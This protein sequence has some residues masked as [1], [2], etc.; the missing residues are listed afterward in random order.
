MCKRIISLLLAA[1]MLLSIPMPVRATEETQP[2]EVV[3]LRYLSISTPEEL[4]A[5]AENCRLDSYSQNLVVM[6]EQDI[7]LTGV[8]FTPIP[9]FSGYFQG[10]GHTI[11]GVNLTGEG[12]AVGFFRY[13]TETAVVE[14]VHVQGEIHP[15]GSRSTVGGISGENRGTIRGSS[16]TG[17][18][19]GGEYVGL[20]VGRNM[21]SGIIESC[22]AAGELHGDHF[23]GGIAG[24]NSGVIRNCE[25]HA[26]INTTPQQNTVD[27]SDITMDTLT[28]SESVNTVTDIGGVAGLSTGVIR[29]CVN[30]G[31]V[32]YQHMGYNIGGIAGTQSGYITDCR[33]YGSVQ[34]RKEVGGIVGQMEPVAVIEYS[35]DTLQIL[36]EQLNDMSGLVSQA[37]GNAYAN[38]SHV[39]AQMGQL[40]N[41]AQAAKDAADYLVPDLKDPTIPD[42]DGILAAQN[43]LSSNLGAMPETMNSIASATQN[44]VSGLGRDLQAVSGQISVM[45]QTVSNASE[46][47]GLTIRDCSDLDTP[48]NL[49]GKVEGCVN[50]GDLLADLNVGGIAGAMA[51]ENDLDIL[52]DWES[53]GEESLNLE[54]NLRAVLLNSENHGTVTGKKQ[55]VGGIVGWQSMGLTRLCS[56]AGNVDGEGASYVGGIS[57]LSTGFIRNCYA[58]SAIAGNTC[59]GGVAGSAGIVTDCLTMVK[60]EGGRESLGA[61]LGTQGQALT[62][63]ENPIAGNIYLSV[64]ADHGAIDGISYAGLAQPM[65]LDEFL[66]ME[67]LPELFRTVTIRF[68]FPD[69]TMTEFPLTTGQSM[70]MDVVPTVPAQAGATGVWEGLQ[71]ADLTDVLFDRTYDVKYTAYTTTIASAETRE[72]GRPIL[73]VEGAF[74]NE[75]V[76]SVEKST[77]SYVPEEGAQL[78]ES[79]VITLTEPGETARFLMPEGAKADKLTLM[80]CGAEGIWRQAEIRQDGSYLVFALESGDRDLALIRKA[81][82]EL[83]L[84]QVAVASSMATAVVVLLLTSLTKKKAKREK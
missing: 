82:L 45:S 33:N 10:G 12:S 61:I 70:S 2:K 5:L 56:S 64:G 63:V 66:A 1:L 9:I 36:Q 7:D 20:I 19:S 22:V 76:V 53:Y 30:Y 65:A 72:N 58:K 4:L 75:A 57:G 6:L 37:A 44:T 32:G 38:A 11:S 54:S 21:V 77:I 40:Q 34:G 62:E 52:Q 71:A 29:G 47:L 41:Q 28:N 79:W 18:L 23:V 68:R 59:V 17:S 78:L 51:M 27:I 46:N 50:Y 42:V 80:V 55:N 67:N 74:T 31:A 60:F 26:A 49:T 25:N 39:S 73:L 16:F 69:G 8:A 35:Q 3:E 83:T 84:V 81:G 13:L 43:T 48:E 14:N 15:A 24:E